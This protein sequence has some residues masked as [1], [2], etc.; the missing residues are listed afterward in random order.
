LYYQCH[1]GTYTSQ[2]RVKRGNRKSELAL[3]E[4]ELWG[5]AAQ[6]LAGMPFPAETIDEAW[7][8]VLLHQ[9]H[10]ILPGSSIHRVYEETEAAH[11]QVIRTAQE[12]A[13][14]ARASLTDG[15]PSAATVFNSLSW[16][17]TALVPLP[18]GWAGAAD[19]A[20][21]PLP[22]Q[23]V[24]GR[25][26]AEVRVP[27]CGWTT[28]RPSPDASD[29][30][31]GALLVKS[32]EGVTLEN[33]HLRVALNDRGEVVS[34]WDK[35]TEREWAAG[36]CNC[37]Q[38]FKDTPTWF[39]AWDIESMVALSPVPL[40][41]PA[42]VETAAQGPLAATVRITRQLRDSR[43]TQEVC[44]RRGS[45]RV[46]FHTA[47]DWQES[48]KLLKAA[49]PV[50]V[51]ADEAIHDI[52]F[53]HIRRP[54][55]D[56]R[57]FDADRFEVCN[58]KW[59]ALAEGNRGFAVLN[60]C[61]YG[62]SVRGGCISLTL[63]KSALAPDMQADK[64]RHEFTYAFYVWDGSL[65]E[66]GVAQAAYDLNCPVTT[67]PG[68]AG[69]RALFAVDAPNVVVET[70]KLADDGSGD[71]IVRLYEGMRMATRCVLSTA[72]PVSGA[73]QADMLE[74][75][76]H[77]LPCDEGRVALDLRAFEVKTIRLRV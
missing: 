51:H 26:F 39:D 13:G 68:A 60:D 25:T 11:A 77:E 72:L 48:H 32:A 73:A 30:G 41:E 37:L 53:G 31:P 62:V 20:G 3:R 7:K 64:G 12:V 50:A 75:V 58:H 38:M 22:V 35:E 45:R 54:N 61:K 10:D 43:V 28:L 56:S 29:P 59:S 57:P 24:D 16:E 23:A 40:D 71:V 34:I 8:T 52:Q 9:F 65:A 55:H 5:A 14:A 33:E 70:V 42:T 1:R 67:A 2:A 18:E 36:P 15:D 6:A 44:L 17:R 46:D 63:L 69:E 49:F 4:A 76:E 27:S 74:R 66:S 21:A 47:V 19:E